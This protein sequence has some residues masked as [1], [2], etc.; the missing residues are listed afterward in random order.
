MEHFHFIQAALKKKKKNATTSL[1]VWANQ[2]VTLAA[3]P[4][5]VSSSTWAQMLRIFNKWE[6]SCSSIA[7]RERSDSA[8]Q[9]SSI[10]FGPPLGFVLP[11]LPSS[12]PAQGLRM[13]L[14][15]T[16][17]NSNKNKLLILF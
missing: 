4:G 11:L 6:K 14:G 15:A 16:A 2:K 17:I 8:A 12:S 13:H 9:G 1:S 10:L 5:G 7:T 3:G